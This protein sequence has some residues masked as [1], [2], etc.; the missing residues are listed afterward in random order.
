MSLFAVL[1]YKII[2]WL[3]SLMLYKLFNYSKFYSKRGVL[4]NWIV[5]HFKMTAS[6]CL[7]MLV[8]NRFQKNI[9]ALRANDASL[10]DGTQLLFLRRCTQRPLLML[11]IPMPFER[12]RSV[13]LP[14]VQANQEAATGSPRIRAGWMALSKQSCGLKKLSDFSHWHQIPL[15][16]KEGGGR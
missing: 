12:E 7:R 15:E 5:L 8:C 10:V 16:R 11:R 3:T 2:M 9:T 13:S 6:E 1:L 14:G 4:G